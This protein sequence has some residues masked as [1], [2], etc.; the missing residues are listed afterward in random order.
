M[1]TMWLL[2]AKKYVK[3]E[4]NNTFSKIVAH[5]TEKSV[6]S[7]RL[8]TDGGHPPFWQLGNDVTRCTCICEWWGGDGVGTGQWW[9]L[10]FFDRMK[11]TD[12]NHAWFLFSGT[13]FTRAIM[14]LSC[15]WAMWMIEALGDVDLTWV[16]HTKEWWGGDKKWWGGNR[17]GWEELAKANVERR[18]CYQ[19]ARYQGK[20]KQEDIK[21][22]VLTKI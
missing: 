6:S 13:T 9:T 8:K 22:K 21:S 4:C 14:T 5:W 18:K 19:T 3:I 17:R 16:V 12:L 11:F 7:C 1:I 2:G 15:S 10:P 20:S